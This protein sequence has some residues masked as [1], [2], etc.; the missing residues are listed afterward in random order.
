MPNR[1]FPLALAHEA[2]DDGKVSQHGRHQ[3][4]QCSQ[5]RD[6]GSQRRL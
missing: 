5:A 3:G 4:S 1:G 2:L 6:Q